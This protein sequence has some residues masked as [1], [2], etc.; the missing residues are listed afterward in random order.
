MAA[1]RPGPCSA[2]LPTVCSASRA[3][4]S[5]E[6]YYFDNV[7]V[8][9]LTQSSM[10]VNASANT[11]ITCTNT[12]VTLSGS[13]TTAGVSYSWTGPNSFSSAVQN[14]STSKEGVYTLKAS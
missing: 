2:R 14:P 7:Q 8:S 11:P 5:D 9:G 3:T 4:G 12:A 1:L 6:F 13:A 10:G